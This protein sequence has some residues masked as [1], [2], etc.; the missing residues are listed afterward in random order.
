MIRN[1]ITYLFH[2]WSKIFL[3]PLKDFRGLSKKWLKIGQRRSTSNK[4]WRLSR[5]WR[6]KAPLT[7]IRRPVIWFLP[8]WIWFCRDEFEFA[9]MNL[10]LPWWIWFCRDE[11]AFAVTDLLLP[12][13]L[14]NCRD[15]FCFYRGCL[16]FA[17]SSLIL[18][19]WIW[20]F[21]N[22]YGPPS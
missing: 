20:Y 9:V 17:V 4:K 16:V 12:W 22:S 10:I 14:L 7:K 15:W 19:F 21:R 11:F 1:E 5:L 8:W 6:E 2:N 13:W 3:P 18:L